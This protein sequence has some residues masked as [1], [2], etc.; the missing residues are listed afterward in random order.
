[1]IKGLGAK[2]LFSFLLIGLT[3]MIIMGFLLKKTTEDYA[4]SVP[5]RLRL[6]AEAISDKIERNLFERYGDVQ[7]FSRNSLLQDRN[8]WHQIGE[9]NNPI[10]GAANTYVALY[11]VYYLTIIVDLD[12]KVIAV[13]DK[14]ATGKS[15][16]TQ[17][18]YDM[19]FKDAEWFGRTVRG[20]YLSTPALTGT[21]VE[22]FHVNSLVKT[23]FKND[24]LAL[25]YSA[26]VPGPDG[27]PIAI[28]HNVTKVSLVEE[29]M[30]EAHARASSLFNWS[31]LEITLL[32]K[33]GTLLLEYDPA[34][35]KTKDCT[36]NMGQ[37]LQ[38]NFA[39]NG[40]SAAQELVQGK[41]GGGRSLHAR[42]KIW[43]ST[44]FA[45]SQGALGY[46]GLKWGVLVRAPETETLAAV[47]SAEKSALITFATT[48]LV[49][50]LLALGIALLIAKPILKVAAELTESA[51]QT[52]RA[53]EEVSSAS[54]GLADGTS[55][56]AS[57][58]EES[59]A[60]LEELSSMTKRNADS[61]SEARH[62]ADTCSDAAK[63]GSKEMSDLSN[64]MQEMLN[65][66]KKIDE[67][68]F[69][70]NILA[71]NAAVEAA[72]AGEAGAGFAVVADEVRNLAQRSA[73]AA[74]E[75]S[76]RITAGVQIGE[77]LEKS[78]Q[79]IVAGDAKMHALASEIALATQE[80]S[81][82][83]KEISSS[84]T[85]ID[86]ITQS[87]A[88]TAEETASAAAEL[89]TQAEA[90]NRLVH[91]LETQI[92]GYSHID[93]T[94]ATTPHYHAAPA[95]RQTAHHAP[96]SESSRKALPFG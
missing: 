55:K 26:P 94:T 79:S 66:I 4:Q 61:S 89:T 31:D 54:S 56:Q 24:G 15:L 32:D 30:T 43:Q 25:S 71:L 19:N 63:R 49:V 38:F 72:R 42:K 68:A 64:A 44:G 8:S 35:D 87:N 86:H 65:I 96:A 9:P 17:F 73:E 95:P 88:A 45:A 84:V 29:I 10:V 60:A 82:G 69:Q 92:R 21:V 23:V 57:A 1:M 5:M 27:A 33:K 41:S 78:F 93:S 76:E 12:G 28:W 85:Q 91:D 70:T 47:H 48:C 36:H 39:Q 52:H 77:R 58:V 2:L 18:I 40:V 59:S 16:D 81:I 75:T 11:C 67:I 14:D 74:S 80:Q 34:R 37:L 51:L 83:V 6:T 7:A 90:L 20:D 22:D 50:T 3:P 53:A 62:Q 46:A 13:N